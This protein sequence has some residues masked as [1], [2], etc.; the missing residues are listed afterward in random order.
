MASDCPTC[1]S[2]WTGG[3]IAPETRRW[4]FTCGPGPKGWIWNFQC[5]SN[6]VILIQPL[7][8]ALPKISEK[9]CDEIL[10]TIANVTCPYTALSILNDR[11][12]RWPDDKLADA[13]G[14]TAARFVEL[15]NR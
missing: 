4:C 5:I 1:I 13:I 12:E 9:E 10:A 15:Y 2:A 11:L 3:H 14:K 7:M 8:Y 6:L